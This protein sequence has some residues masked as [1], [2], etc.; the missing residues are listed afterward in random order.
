MT[1]NVTV[2]VYRPAD[3]LGSGEAKPTLVAQA[4]PAGAL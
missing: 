2:A 4:S 3:T 1:L